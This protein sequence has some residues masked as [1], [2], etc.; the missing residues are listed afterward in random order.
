METKPRVCVVDENPLVEV[1]WKRSLGGQAQ[2]FY[3]R[4]P[5]QLLKASEEEPKLLESFQ[6]V[7]MGRMYPHIEMDLITT[8]IPERIRPRLRAPLFLNWQGFV[9]RDYLD[10]FFD[11]K[12]FHRYGIK[13]HTLRL[14]MQRL[15][16]KEPVEP[17]LPVV[18]L[19]EASKD[20]S[21][22]AKCRELLQTMLLKAEGKHRKKIEHYAVNDTMT[23]I[24]LLEAIYNQ[25]LIDKNR[26]EN[27]PSRYI[28]SS[29]VIAA[30]LLREALHH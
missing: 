21:R 13:W 20:L 7:V 1:G 6:C 23:G 12:V 27:C 19:P 10:K 22:A 25:L 14:R 2:L 29:P 17:I 4:D 15:D 16:R 28:N 30:R 18:N 3:Y 26:P 11:G 8:D 5:L 24:R 9:S